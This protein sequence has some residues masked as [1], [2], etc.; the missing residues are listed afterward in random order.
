MNGATKEPAKERR[1]YKVVLTG[2]PCGGK[3][4]TQARMS[5]FFEDIGWKV[6]KVPETATLLLS[7][8][9]KFAELDEE[10]DIEAKEWKKLMDANQWNTIQLRDERYDQIIHLLSSACGA[11]AFYSK[12]NNLAR[13]EGLELARDLDTKTQQAWVG[14]PYFDVIDNTIEF[15]AKVLKAIRAVCTKIGIEVGDR[16]APNSIKRKFLVKCLPDEKLFPPFQDFDVVHDYLT[17]TDL[18]IGTQARLR[19]RGQNGRYTYMH[20]TRRPKIDDQ[21]VEVR[22]SLDR[23][24]YELLLA[25]RDENRQSVYKKRRCFLWKNQYYQLDVYREPYHA[26][27]KGL[28]LLETYTTKST[29]NLELPSFLEIEKEVTKDPDFSMYHLSLKQ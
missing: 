13:S 17:V 18:E 3:T 25:Q 7:G 8:G 28:I 12:A 26:R 29:E 22:R 20:T 24:D 27:C 1:V 9:V 4:T 6:F 2:G 21:V 5:T 15:D 10:S 23:R 14:H 19:R 16:F 11:E